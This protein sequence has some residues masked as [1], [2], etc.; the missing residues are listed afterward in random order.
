MGKVVMG[1]SDR[2]RSVYFDTSIYNRL[3][4][5][6]EKD[7]IIELIGKNSL[8]VI[9]SVVNMCELLMTS[10][11]SRKDALIRIYN[12]IRNDMHPLKPFVWLL[13]ESVE[14][15]QKGLKE[16][17]IN[18]PI[19]MGQKAESIC[20]KIFNKKEEDIKSSFKNA[21]EFIKNK[22][23]KGKLPD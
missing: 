12:E 11:P 10:D 16:W 14:A 7:Q 13:K 17:E 5:D 22:V 19:E 2:S 1:L 18:Y 9:P 23:N 8:I 21:R 20:R 3:L 4:D 15:V 6:P